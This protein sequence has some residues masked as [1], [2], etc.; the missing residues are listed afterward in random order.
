[1]AL[2]PSIIFPSI[3]I[4]WPSFM[5]ISL[6]SFITLV[7]SDMLISWSIGPVAFPS[8]I[9]IILPSFIM[10]PLISAAMGREAKR[11]ADNNTMAVR[12]TTRY[13]VIS[14]SSIVLQ[15]DTLIAHGWLGPAGG[16]R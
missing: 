9:I 6:P 12:T 13:V 4:I 14:E 8:I 3:I 10:T 11:D 15:I 1:M 7:P 2:P 16:A 5:C